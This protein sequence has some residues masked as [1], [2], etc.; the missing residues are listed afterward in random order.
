MLFVIFVAS[1]FILINRY[2]K[3]FTS[4]PTHQRIKQATRVSPTPQITPLSLRDAIG[5]EEYKKVMNSQESYSPLIAKDPINEN[6][7]LIQGTLTEITNN[8]VKINA[9]GENVMV[10]ITGQQTFTVYQFEER[11]GFNHPGL[12]KLPS[13]VK[14]IAELNQ[15]MQKS[16]N[17]ST[18]KDGTNYTAQRVSIYE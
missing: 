5:P 1:A 2:Y 14:P 8:T 17:I 11:P 6:T 9:H 18:R 3:Q 4:P 16:I 15:Y 13:V 10:N 7:Y 12:T